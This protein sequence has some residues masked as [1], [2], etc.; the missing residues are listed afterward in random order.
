MNETL[1]YPTNEYVRHI[2]QT[3]LHPQSGTPYWIKRDA[4]K[5]TNAY[6][7]VHTFEDFKRLVCFQT[8]EE[9]FQFER[10]TRME[11]L[12]NFIPISVRG[13]RRIW[14]SETGGTTGIPK[15]GCWDEH[16]WKHTLDF[17]DHFLDAFGTPRN[18]NWLFAGPM[19]P[20]T[21]GRLI[22][23]ITENRGGLCFTIDLDPRF[24]KI[25]GH[26]GQAEMYE[27]YIRHIWDQ[28]AFIL[29]SQ[30][31]E[32]LFATSRLLEM[33][34][35]YIDL[36]LLKNI[37][38]IVHAGTEMST[39]TNRLLKEKIFGDI[40]IIGIYGTSTTGIHFQNLSLPGSRVVYIPCSPFVVLEVID[41]DGRVCNYE[42]EGNIA[43]YR[44]TEDFLIPGFWERDRGKRVKAAG[45]MA[46]TYPWD[47]VGDLYSPEFRKEGS[48]EG[49]Y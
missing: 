4:E 26:E 44:L 18:A 7:D 2:V 47:W 48:V 33:L 30:K 19:G 49:V 29:A 12:E 37:K 9:Q 36:K 13:Q 40:P 31:I 16:Y 6:R 21:T 5:K 34:P 10:A 28:V 25:L 8:S 42:E 23:S 39:E 1:F 3:H 27:R 38:A 15:H 32:V 24:I 11:P 20:H 35:E 22:V 43:T 46:A 45:E 14:A 41:D 17:S